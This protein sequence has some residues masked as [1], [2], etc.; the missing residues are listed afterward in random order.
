MLGALIKKAVSGSF[1]T[2]DAWISDGRVESFINW[3]YIGYIK[4]IK[5]QVLYWNQARDME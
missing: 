2:T 4:K 5:T 3:E 1:Q